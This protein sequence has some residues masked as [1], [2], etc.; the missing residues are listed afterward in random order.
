M[1]L[2]SQPPP[3][4]PAHE[5]SVPMGDDSYHSTLHISSQIDSLE[6]RL[7]PIMHGTAPIRPTRLTPCKHD[8]DDFRCSFFRSTV[9]LLATLARPSLGG[10]S[11]TPSRRPEGL[12]IPFSLPPVAA[13]QTRYQ[14][15][16]SSITTS[17]MFLAAHRC[18]RSIKKFS[19][20]PAHFASMIR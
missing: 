8:R 6:R 1:P 20:T 9:A 2:P 7:S 12:K 3:P 4:P 17:P 15:S 19:S 11:P 10:T 13:S 5:R 18:K 14:S 16:C